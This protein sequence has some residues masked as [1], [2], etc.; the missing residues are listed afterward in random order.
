M[1]LVSGFAIM[2]L[3]HFYFTGMT[4][5]MCLMNNSGVSSGPIT[6]QRISP[7]D[8]SDLPTSIHRISHIF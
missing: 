2:T 1:I 8:F 7:D 4:S 3:M 6:I 5:N